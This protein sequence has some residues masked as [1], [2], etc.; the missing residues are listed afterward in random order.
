MVT[1]ATANMDIA[2]GAI[3]VVQLRM[4]VSECYGHIA[5]GFGWASRQLMA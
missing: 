3:D 5:G 1:I 2:D 4:C